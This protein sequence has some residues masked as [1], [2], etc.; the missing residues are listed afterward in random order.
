MGSVSQRS[1]RRI[2]CTKNH[3]GVRKRNATPVKTAQNTWRDIDSMHS[4]DP[5]MC[6]EYV[7]DIYTNLQ[8]SE[9]VLYPL[10]DYIEKVQTD[11][12]STMRGILVDWLV[13]VAE[14]YKLSDDTLFLSVLYLDRCLSIR[15]VAR[16]RLQLLGITCMLVASKYEEIYAPQVDEFCYITDNTYTREDVLS[17][18]R[19][20]LDS[21]NFD[22]T[23][24]TTKTFLRRCL[25]AA[26]S[27]V[28][29]D[30]LAGFLSELALLEYTFLRYSQSTIAAASVSLALMTLGRSPWSKT[31]EHYTHMFPCDLR[32]CVQALHTC[33]LAAQQSSLSAVREKYSQMK[34]KCVSLIKPVDSCAE[35][36]A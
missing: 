33:H 27:D 28:K 12:S 8:K 15:T 16:S 13:E 1:E 20:V 19:I 32:E 25:S 23:H 29:V 18:E 5:L 7:D 26:E 17:M 35:Y 34:F 11:I 31:L 10:S 21:L 6:S 30:F 24:P 9:V 4:D 3:A 2:G 14:E 36:S 22:L